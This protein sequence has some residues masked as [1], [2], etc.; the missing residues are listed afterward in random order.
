MR[1]V[2]TSAVE[3]IHALG[4]RLQALHIHDNDK[5][6][7]SHQIP[8]SMK[9]DFEAV[10]KALKDIGYQGYLTL[11]ADAYLRGRTAENIFDGM[12]NMAAAARKLNELM[13]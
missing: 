9:I 12:V 2:D 5:W 10:A 13:V 3:M 11:E 4:H 7:D 1:G 6:Q 8:F